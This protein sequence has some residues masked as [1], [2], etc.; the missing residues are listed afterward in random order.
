[1]NISIHPALAST[2]PAVFYTVAVISS[3]DLL[4]L[5]KHYSPLPLLESLG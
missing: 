2:P 3:T 4:G 5:V 1:M